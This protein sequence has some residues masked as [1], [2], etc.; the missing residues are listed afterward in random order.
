[1]K[2]LLFIGDVV[3]SLGCQFL[4]E[5]LP[6]IKR[7]YDIDITVVNG[8]NSAQGNGITHSSA[9]S[10]IRSGVDIITT[11]NH[12]FRRHESHELFENSYI[13]RPA[14][15]PDGTPGS[16]ICT[17]D[18]GSFSVTVINL[19]G[20]VYM[21]SLDNPFMK[22]DEI[23]SDIDSRN[24]FLDFHAEATSEKKSM[25]FYLAERVTGIFGTHTHVQ[26][27][28]ETI[29]KGHTAYITDA[30]MTGVELS[31]LGVDYQLTI[32]HM[33]SH[34]PVKFRGAEGKCFLCGVVVEFDEKCGKAH[35]IQRII[36]R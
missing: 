25:G 26:T 36:V 35:S 6:A 24:I 34:M 5:K 31:C 17:L 9:E 18:M 21:D 14:N 3:G 1:M 2:R 29:L 30:G 20:V 11:G 33:R 4:S 8:E 19:M 23:L 7:K 16:G 10:I 32:E 12:A 22:I 27:A 13:I 15:Y 28:D